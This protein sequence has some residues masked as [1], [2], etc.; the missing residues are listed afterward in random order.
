MSG[1]VLRAFPFN[2]SLLKYKLHKHLFSI[3]FQTFAGL[4]VP[5]HGEPA[6]PFSSYGDGWGESPPAVNGHHD[7]GIGLTNRGAY[8]VTVPPQ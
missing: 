3:D 6:Y 5:K 2:F 4:D 1:F 8:D 7:N